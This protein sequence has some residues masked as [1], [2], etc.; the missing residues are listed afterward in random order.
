V[1]ST[2]PIAGTRPRGESALRDEALRTELRLNEK[3]QAEHVMLVDLE[4]NDL[5][6]I[7][8]GGTVQVTSS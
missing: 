1:A 4:R 3:E 5:G 2:R 8:R 7:C 6:R